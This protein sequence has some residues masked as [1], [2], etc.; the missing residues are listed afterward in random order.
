MSD[1]SRRK[2]LKSI[3]AGS[4]AVIAGKNLPENWTKPVVDSVMLPAH[5][6]TS[7]CA[8]GITET[9]TGIIPYSSTPPGPNVPYGLEDILTITVAPAP[10]DGQ[11][12]LLEVYV[13]GAFSGA[14]NPVLTGGVAST[15]IITNVVASA[16]LRATYDCAV[17][18]IFFNILPP[19]GSPAP[20]GSGNI[21][22]G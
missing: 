18:S 8:F 2:L 22:S 11:T 3:A 21:I 9:T 10:A 13:N 17:T 4:G 16:E 15:P 14:I 20:V 6:Q 12:V 7:Q 1:K 19:Q 5:A